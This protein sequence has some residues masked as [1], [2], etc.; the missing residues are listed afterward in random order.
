MSHKP[1]NARTGPIRA[2]SGFS[3]LV[4]EGPDAEAFLQAQ[5]MNDVRALA[6][7]Q[8]QWN[9]WLNPKG[10]VI[11]LFVLLRVGPDA[12]WLV[13]PDIPASELLP[14]LQRYVFRSKLKLAVLE[15]WRAGAECGAEGTEAGALANFAEGGQDA[16][17]RLDFTGEAG[18]RWLHLLPAGHPGLQ[19]PDPDTDRRWHELDLLHGLPRLDA[20][21]REAWTPQMLSLDRLGAYSLKKGCYPGQEIVARTHYLGQAKRGL[22]G[23]LGQGLLPGMDISDGHSR[24]GTVA[25]ASPDGRRGLAV[26]ASELPDGVELRTDTGPASRQPLVAGLRR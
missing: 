20:S 8:W 13:L 14:L 23:I 6:P 7:L 24:V 4:V 10:R 25:C 5:T 12:Y 16:G 9:G 11:A 22:A 18:S 1:N 21:Q 3:V 15:N 2:L 17:Y 19:G 26:L